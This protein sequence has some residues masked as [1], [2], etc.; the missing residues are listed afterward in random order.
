MGEF[1][2]KGN[3]VNQVL[4]ASGTRTTDGDSG[5]IYIKDGYSRL[6]TMLNVS[7]VSGTSPS[8]TV[9]VEIR[10]PVSGSWYVIGQ[11]TPQTG[12]SGELICIGAGGDTKFVAG[13]TIRVRWT[14]TGTTPSFTFSVG[15]IQVV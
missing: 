11:F 13:D 5:A 9:Y 2:I 3:S 4:V 14:I 8:L 7:A 6:A 1:Q 15:A 12:I 10:D